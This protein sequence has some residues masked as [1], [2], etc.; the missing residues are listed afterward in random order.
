MKK[1]KKWL[2]CMLVLLLLL[3]VLSLPMNAEAA[4]VDVDDLVFT[5]NPDGESYSV[6]ARDAGIRGELIIPA[7]YEGKP[8]TVIPERAFES[9]EKLTGDLVIPNTVTSI[10]DYA[11]FACL[12]LKG[13]LVISDGVTSIGNY[14]FAWCM[15]LTGDLIIPNSVTRIGDSAFIECKGLNGE[16]I[17]SN[18]L[19]VIDKTVFSGCNGIKGKLVIPN[20]VTSIGDH[21]FYKLEKIEEISLSKNLLNIGQAA[22]YNMQ[23]LT[24]VWYEGST[25]DKKKM[26]ILGENESLLNATWHYSGD[27]VESF[28][29]QLYNVCLNRD[30]DLTG[31]EAWTNQL[32][33]GNEA[34]ISA[35]Y[36]F[37]FSQEFLEKNLC[38][39]DYVKQLYEAFLGR[40]ADAAGLAAWVSVLEAGRTREHV[41][42]GF[43]LSVEFA[44]FCDAYG[45]VRGKGIAEYTN[46]TVPTGPCTVCGKQD[47][48]VY[49]EGVIRFVRR[50]YSVC[51]E[52]EADPSGLESWSTLLREQ[53]KNGHDVAYGFIF[54]EEFTKKNYSDEEYVE[55]LYKIF[56]GRSADPEGKAMWLDCIEDGKTRLGVFE[57]FACSDEFKKICDEY[58]IK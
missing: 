26:Q 37:I 43:A 17:L 48:V 14:A 35:A 41:F 15:N 45:I 20:S 24:D 29:I 55:N 7:M 34:G 50:L 23:S 44:E 28:V 10:G 39:E 21:S 36:G 19:S 51:L 53:K 38:N 46:G 40:E 5:L 3:G 6:E 16:L 22:F 31:L 1:L 30:P 57:G 32:K 54:S 56:M 47:P 27:P 33:T 18:S 8:V 58:G 12:G 42:N 11:F 13:K 4:T 2:P 25:V 49:E 9:C 52:R